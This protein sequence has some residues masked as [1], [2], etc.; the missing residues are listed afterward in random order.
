MDFA[1][2]KKAGIGQQEFADLVGVSR[3]SV[4]NWVTGKNQPSRHL[5]PK[6]KQQLTL[7]L[8]ATR[9]KTL[10]GEIPTMHKTNVSSRQEYIRDKLADAESILRKRKA[11]QVAKAKARRKTKK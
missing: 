10:P 5:T 2:L 7:L 11:Q 9:L 4:N 1:I 6:V 3:I 8:A